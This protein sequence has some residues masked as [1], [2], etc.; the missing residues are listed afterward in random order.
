MA[1][2]GFPA[3]V[4]AEP[5]EDAR[6]IWGREGQRQSRPRPSKRASASLFSFFYIFSVFLSRP[7][8]G[9]KGRTT[10]HKY[11]AFFFACLAAAIREAV[12]RLVSLIAFAAECPYIFPLVVKLLSIRR[13][14]NR[15]ALG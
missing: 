3:P 5:G 2:R 4:W 10:L 6:R 8:F 13:S 7:P 11:I 15:L 12:P 1:A 14:I 9:V